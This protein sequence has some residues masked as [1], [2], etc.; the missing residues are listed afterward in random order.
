MK[1]KQHTSTQIALANV[2]VLALYSK[3]CRKHLLEQGKIAKEERTQSERETENFC[4]W[5]LREQL[6]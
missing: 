5:A 3:V 2:C 1:V 6:F 4:Q